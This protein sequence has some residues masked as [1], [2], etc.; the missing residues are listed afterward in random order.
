MRMGWAL[1]VFILSYTE[2]R[3]QDVHNL[4]QALKDFA[5]L[6]SKEQDCTASDAIEEKTETMVCTSSPGS[7]SHK[8]PDKRLIYKATKI[9]EVPEPMRKMIPAGTNISESIPFYFSLYQDND[10]PFYNGGIGNDLG[11]TF[12]AQ[13][14]IGITNKKG[15]TFG[16]SY[17]T[18]INSERKIEVEKDGKNYYKDFPKN[19]W[20]AFRANLEKGELVVEQPNKDQHVLFNE[21]SIISLFANNKEQGKWYIWDF[22]AGIATLN[23][24]N[25]K[26]LGA[27][28]IQRNWH[29]LL[30]I[31][32]FKY[33]PDKTENSYAAYLK[34][35]VGVQKI[36]FD[37]KNCSVKVS[38]SFGG[39]ADIGGGKRTFLLTELNADLG[40]IGK[41]NP[42]EKLIHLQ[43]GY[44]GK[45]GNVKQSNIKAGFS[46]DFHRIILTNQVA[47]P[48]AKDGYTELATTYMDKDP[49]YRIGILVPLR[50][51]K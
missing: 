42:N 15:I 5:N 39:S 19:D 45:L 44:D 22:T 14:E 50:I 23:S 43:A 46:I 4:P 34:A 10:N 29:D 51:K 28:N 47:I 13:V 16:A 31:A 9:E 26:G 30:K 37:E 2:I 7:S 8:V 12:G 21:N 48:L 11:Y 38:G 40:L 25:V 35:M 6:N 27:A 33:I 41:K 1:L 36:L 32:N 17:Y 20:K 18:G 49:I 3:A 24:Q